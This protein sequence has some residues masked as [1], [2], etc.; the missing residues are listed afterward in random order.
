MYE[1]IVPSVLKQ[2]LNKRK[3]KLEGFY[4]SL[5]ISSSSTDSEDSNKDKN[6]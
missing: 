2:K 5:E 3:Y 1:I 4:E 6:L